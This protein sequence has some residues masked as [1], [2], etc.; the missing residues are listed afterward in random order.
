MA[1]QEA[2]VEQRRSPVGRAA[3]IESLAGDSHLIVVAGLGADGRER[4]VDV[5]DVVARRMPCAGERLQFGRDVPERVAVL[6]DA[7]EFHGVVSHYSGGWSARDARSGQS[8]AE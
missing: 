1:P 5:L 8:V 3:A 4:H 2:E 6:I 7:D